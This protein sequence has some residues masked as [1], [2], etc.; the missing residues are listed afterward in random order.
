MTR[1]ELAREFADRLNMI[2]NDKDV[3]SRDIERETG[4]SHS[5]I[6]GWQRGK[7]PSAYAVVTLCEYFGV[8]A[9][10]LLGL[11]DEMGREA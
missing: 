11:S 8:S 2:K 7:I 10:W 1:E 4:L 5:S 6:G 3:T 9:D